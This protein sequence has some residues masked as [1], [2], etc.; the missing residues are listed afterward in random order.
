MCVDGIQITIE[1]I[2]VIRLHVCV[3]EENPLRFCQVEKTVSCVTSTAILRRADQPG[4]TREA[5]YLPGQL[6]GERG[7]VGAVIENQ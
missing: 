4:W 7:I 6:A 5:H 3:Q 1:E 2:P